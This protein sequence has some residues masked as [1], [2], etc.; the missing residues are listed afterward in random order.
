MFSHNNVTDYDRSI[1]ENFN[2]IEIETNTE[3]QINILVDIDPIS[4]WKPMKMLLYH[5][6]KT[7][8]TNYPLLYRYNIHN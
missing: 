2:N 3:N 6:M 8:P 7:K 4:I 1:L 5:V